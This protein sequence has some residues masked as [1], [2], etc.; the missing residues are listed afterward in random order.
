MIVKYN[1][2]MIKKKRG[3]NMLASS[4]S[5]AVRF[6]LPAVIGIVVVGDVYM[7][8]NTIEVILEFNRL[9]LDNYDKTSDKK[10]L[11]NLQQIPTGSMTIIIHSIGVNVAKKISIF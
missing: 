1:D 6:T 2:L 10:L 3:Y 5:R 9:I 11:A 7:H 8:Q 4:L